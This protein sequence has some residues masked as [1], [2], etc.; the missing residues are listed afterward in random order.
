MSGTAVACD[1]DVDSLVTDLLI[2]ILLA[3]F[4]PLGI[5]CLIALAG[6]CLCGSIFGAFRMSNYS[7]KPVFKTESNAT[8]QRHT[9]PIATTSLEATSYPSGPPAPSPVYGKVVA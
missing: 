2:I 7:R 8:N 5:C 6:F 9:N 3:I 1:L 4:I